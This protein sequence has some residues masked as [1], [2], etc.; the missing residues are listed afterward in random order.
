MKNLY[1]ITVRKTNGSLEVF[2]GE[3]H[4]LAGAVAE[5]EVTAA[6]KDLPK[7]DITAA[8]LLGEKSF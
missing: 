4:S 3:S 8:T 2:Y 5:I 1:M 7:P 6:K